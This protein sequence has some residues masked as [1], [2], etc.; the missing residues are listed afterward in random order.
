MFI[1]NYL[2]KSLLL[3]LTRLI[4]QFL[5]SNLFYIDVIMIGGDFLRLIRRD[6][7]QRKCAKMGKKIEGADFPNVLSNLILGNESHLNNQ[8]GFRY[9]IS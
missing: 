2:G 7:K 5:R 4:S 6:S 9:F 3:L 8:K 1:P